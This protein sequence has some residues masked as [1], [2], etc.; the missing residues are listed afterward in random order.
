MAAK[1]P[2]AKLAKLEAD[3]AAARA[4]KEKKAAAVEAVKTKI[5]GLLA[6]IAALTETGD[7]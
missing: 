6:A 5:G 1:K 7:E 4:D 3:L 2:S